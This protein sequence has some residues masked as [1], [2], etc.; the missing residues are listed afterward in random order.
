M[1]SCLSILPSYYQWWLL[2]RYIL[3]VFP[4]VRFNLILYQILVT[5]MEK[6]YFN[7]FNHI[8]FDSKILNWKQE[9]PNEPISR[10]FMG[11]FGL[12]RILEYLMADPQRSISLFQLSVFW[13]YCL[14]N[15]KNYSCIFWLLAL[16]SCDTNYHDVLV[17]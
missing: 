10:Q 13:E 8:N 3:K 5:Q 12:G 14:K 1:Y 11:T 7:W 15:V 16:P 4:D 17:W 6:P 2:Y 9:S